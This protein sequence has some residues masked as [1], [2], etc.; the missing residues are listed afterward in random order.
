MIG[1]FL[2][3]WSHPYIFHGVYSFTIDL[4]NERNLSCFHFLA[5]VTRI[6]MHIAEQVSLK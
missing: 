2:Q 5:I 3:N 6:V 1:F 4:S